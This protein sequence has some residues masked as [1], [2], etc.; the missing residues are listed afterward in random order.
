MSAPNA[1]RQVSVAPPRINCR[2]STLPH[3]PNTYLH[4]TP[5]PIHPSIQRPA[6]L[7]HPHNPPSFALAGSVK[8]TEARSPP[9]IPAAGGVDGHLRTTASLAAFDQALS[10]P[11]LP[12]RSPIAG[13]QAAEPSLRK[14]CLR[15]RGRL[16][17]GRKERVES[18]EWERHHDEPAAFLISSSTMLPEH[19]LFDVDRTAEVWRISPFHHFERSCG[20]AGVCLL[21]RCRAVGG[22]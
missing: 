5:L 9:A 3:E 22:E 20:D 21:R 8:D 2:S 10:R 6:P 4:N 7:H 19:G 1:A 16:S 11:L 12:P 14:L 15:G 18:P 17:D 13:V